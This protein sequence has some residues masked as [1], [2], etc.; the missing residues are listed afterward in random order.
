MLNSPVTGASTAASITHCRLGPLSL[1]DLQSAFPVLKYDDPRVVYEDWE[2]NGMHYFGMRT[3]KN[4]MHGIV[5]IVKPFSWIMEATF[6]EG[7]CHGLQ[8]FIKE[9]GSYEVSQ[10]RDG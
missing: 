10:Y 1:S 5:R 2:E 8:R 9:A 4:V 3:K 7:K 6:K